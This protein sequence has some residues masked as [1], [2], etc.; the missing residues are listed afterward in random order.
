MGGCTMKKLFLTLSMAAIPVAFTACG[1]SVERLVDDMVR[2]GIRCE[3]KEY[4]QA[5][6]DKLTVEYRERK[7]KFTE[8]EQK[9]VEKRVFTRFFEELAILKEKEKAKKKKQ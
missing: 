1:D 8:E 9:E 4:D 5:K 3:T 7:S 6:C 2:D